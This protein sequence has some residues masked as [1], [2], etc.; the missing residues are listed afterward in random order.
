[1]ELVCHKKR[2]R[3]VFVTI[4]H[5]V[6]S[7]IWSIKT[8][9]TTFLLGFMYYYRQHSVRKYQSV[10]VRLVTSVC[11]SRT[12]INTYLRDSLVYLVSLQ[13]QRLFLLSAMLMAYGG[14]GIIAKKVT[15]YHSYNFVIMIIIL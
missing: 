1:M 9:T 13:I 2:P 8:S 11:G 14:I 6:K 7:I 15:F 3:V 10:H 12:G 5:Y 4:H